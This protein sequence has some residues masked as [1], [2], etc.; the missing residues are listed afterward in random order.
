MSISNSFFSHE[1]LQE[2]KTKLDEGKILNTSLKLEDKISQRKLIGLSVVTFGAYYAWYKFTHSKERVF[3]KIET[4]LNKQFNEKISE[5][6][7][8]VEP[9]NLGLFADLHF[10]GFSNINSADFSKMHNAI[11]EGLKK[12]LEKLDAQEVYNWSPEL[13]INR[14]DSEI[15]RDLVK[16]QKAIVL[17]GI[18]EKLPP[19]IKEENDPLSKSVLLE[20]QQ[21]AEDK[22]LEIE[23]F[24]GDGEIEWYAQKHRTYNPLYTT[25]FTITNGQVLEEVN[26]RLL[27]QA[28][29]SPL[30]SRDLNAYFDESK[31]TIQDVS[32]VVSSLWGK[33]ER[34]DKAGVQAAEL[35]KLVDIRGRFEKELNEIN[36]Q[37]RMDIDAF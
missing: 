14:G 4:K 16:D 24:P 22:R 2:I 35:R 19:M 12:A 9:K 11:L 15:I 3:K 27:P 18:K 30:K 31:K 32:Q 25:P 28:P 36:S 13:D 23:A 1:K 10:A 6:K 34:K 17:Q 37:L 20:I 21:L 29:S 7:S 26:K 5:L 33:S 8:R